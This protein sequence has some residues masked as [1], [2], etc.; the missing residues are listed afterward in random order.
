MPSG[1][2]RS[3]N[4][5]LNLVSRSS[6]ISISSSSSKLSTSSSRTRLSKSFARLPLGI[7]ISVTA[8]TVT[9]GASLWQR[10]DHAG[11]QGAPPRRDNFVKLR[12]RLNDPL[13][14]PV[15]PPRSPMPKDETHRAAPGS[16]LAQ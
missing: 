14:L 9:L 3:R 16:D 10:Q 6:S 2:G 11:A 8:T 1:S 5:S 4:S 15:V 12:L 13:E 7:D